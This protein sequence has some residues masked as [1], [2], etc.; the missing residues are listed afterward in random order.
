MAELDLGKVV[1]DN[2]VTP[3]ITAT[4]SVDANTGV[5]SVTVTQSGT[6][7]EPVIDFAFHNLKG[8][9][10]FTDN[11]R[12]TIVTKSTGNYDAALTVKKYL[13]NTLVSS[14]DYLYSSL[15]T[16]V[17]FDGFFTLLYGNLKYT[18]TLLEDSTT[19][20]AGYTEQ[21]A[22]N[23]SVSLAQTFIMSGMNMV[24]HLCTVSASNWSATTDA[25][26]YYTNN[27]SFGGTKTIMPSYRP[28]IGICGSTINIKETPAQSAA[29]SLCSAFYFADNDIV[30]GMTVK[31]KTKPTETFYVTV[32]GKGT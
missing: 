24:T 11:L 19:E 9:D 25:D 28:F 26:G 12:Y 5:P 13:N 1:G 3:D 16:P 8:T 30:T 14:T 4:A 7:E 23:T 20:V 10:S 15:Q 18:L 22:Y 29:Y 21:W 2:G 6:T 27:V 32:N 31:A 17:N